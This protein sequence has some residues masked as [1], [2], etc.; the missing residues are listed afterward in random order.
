MSTS[1]PDRLNE[2]LDA[3]RT[4]VIEVQDSGRTAT[5]DVDSAGPIGARVRSVRVSAPDRPDL[6]T[7]V[8]DLPDALRSLPE[9][10]EPVE[11]DPGLGGASLR[12]RP[13][14]MHD[15]EFFEV[16]VRGDEV[17]VERWRAT[18]EGRERSD[19]DLTRRQLGRLLDELS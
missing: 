16:V 19:F 7:F 6:E 2:A 8:R 18:A 15:S 3:G 17:A 11:V 4:G 10:V 1:L 14:D 5:V 9:R 13:Q 12:T